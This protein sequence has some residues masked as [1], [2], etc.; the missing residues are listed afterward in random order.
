MQSAAHSENRAVIGHAGRLWRRSA[1][2]SADTVMGRLRVRRNNWRFFSN[3]GCSGG[4]GGGGGGGTE[5]QQS[6]KNQKEEGEKRNLP[7]A[8]TL[9]TFSRLGCTS[10]RLGTGGRLGSSCSSRASRRLGTCGAGRGF[11]RRFRASRGFGASGAGGR[12]GAGG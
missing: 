5:L 12:L 9:T 8:K 1:V 6:N 10:R 2:I 11:R 4:G 3:I 7:S